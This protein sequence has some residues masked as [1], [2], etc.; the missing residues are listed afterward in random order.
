MGAFKEALQDW[1][2]GLSDLKVAS[3]ILVIFGLTKKVS[4]TRGEFVLQMHRCMHGK[5][6][7]YKI[8]VSSMGRGYGRV[9]RGTT[10]KH[11]NFRQ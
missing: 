5:L 7:S 2:F 8:W 10:I 3:T 11:S 1:R 9:Q 4:S 6:V